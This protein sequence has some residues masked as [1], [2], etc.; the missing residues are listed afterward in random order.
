MTLWTAVGLLRIYSIMY[1]FL[2]PYEA[3]NF[4]V[5]ITGSNNL[6]SGHLPCW[7]ITM[8]NM[9]AEQLYVHYYIIFFYWSICIHW[10]IN[11]IGGS[12]CKVYRSRVQYILNCK[13]VL[14]YTCPLLQ[15]KAT[16]TSTVCVSNW[17]N[18]W[19]SL[20]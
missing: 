6:L 20:L 18:L 2:M 14:F 15:T 8:V 4:V 5:L 19:S 3:E 1:W 9:P 11:T 7:A 13:H 17:M 12:G 10:V 16:I